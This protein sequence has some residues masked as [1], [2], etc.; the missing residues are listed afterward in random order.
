MARLI[1]FSI[2]RE[3]G[4]WSII[5]HLHKIANS[6]ISFK[7]NQCTIAIKIQSQS[8]AF[9]SILVMHAR[10]LPRISE[11]SFD[12]DYSHTNSYDGGGNT[13][14]GKNN[15][16]KYSP[17]SSAKDKIKNSSGFG[18]C[19]AGEDYLYRRSL[20]PDS[21]QDSPRGMNASS[22]RGGG[23][24]SIKGFSR[25]TRD[26]TER[27]SYYS[28]SKY[29][30]SRNDRDNE[31]TSSYLERNSSSRRERDERERVRDRERSRSPRQNNRKSGWNDPTRTS[32]NLASDRIGDK[33]ESG[34]SGSTG[35]SGGTN[36]SSSNSSN[37]IAPLETKVRSVGD[38]SE[39]TSSSGKKYYYNCVSEVSRKLLIAYTTSKDMWEK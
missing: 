32:R 31:R 21:R 26:R 24:S 29:S 34:S 37:V 15:Y 17:H 6:W 23:D 38:W 9:L 16:T 13:G 3:H 18:S 14:G 30:S 20:S 7:A 5:K 2:I 35:S 12:K 39:H 33:S 22:R 8:S 1:L 27:D 28:S 11:P 25:S 4:H 10:K 19:R 36:S